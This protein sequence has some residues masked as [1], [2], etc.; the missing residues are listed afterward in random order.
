MLS[1]KR[2]FQIE[3][4]SLRDRKKRLLQLWY[5]YYLYSYL[6]LQYIPIDFIQAGV[7]QLGLGATL[8][9]RG[10]LSQRPVAASH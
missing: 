2:Y 5:G 3:H 4:S 9:R 1:T 10:S 7:A 8:N 6:D